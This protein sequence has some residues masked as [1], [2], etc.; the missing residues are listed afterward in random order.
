ML[1]LGDLDEKTSF[2]REN[3]KTKIIIKNSALEQGASRW[4]APSVSLV[5]KG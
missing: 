2:W 1:G 4:R 5:N 3:E